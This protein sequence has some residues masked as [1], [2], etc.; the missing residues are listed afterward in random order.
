MRYCFASGKTCKGRRQLRRKCE[1]DGG[2]SGSGSGSGGGVDGGGLVVV[3][4][5]MVVVVDAVK[6]T[7]QQT[8]AFSPLLN[9]QRL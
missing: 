7:W 9:F 1:D 3:V 6:L 2:G 5:V 4:V 8:K